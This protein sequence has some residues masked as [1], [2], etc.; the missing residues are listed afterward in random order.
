[1]LNLVT[2]AKPFSPCKV[3]YIGSMADIDIQVNHQ[4]TACTALIQYLAR[5]LDSIFGDY[6][7]RYLAAFVY[8]RPVLTRKVFITT[9]VLENFSTISE[10][11]FE[12]SEQKKF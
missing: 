5:H 8:L 2:F 9:C 3:S 1:M 10:F 11:I 12:H 4:S 7:F 6:S